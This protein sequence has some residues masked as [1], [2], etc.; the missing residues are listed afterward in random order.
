MYYFD[1]F[2]WHTETEIPGRATEVSPPSE[3]PLGLAANWT[4]YNWML[5]QY[6]PPPVVNPLEEQW[7]SVRA[8]RNQ[9]LKDTDWTQLADISDPMKTINAIYRA[10][11][12]S[13]PQVQ[14]DP[15]NI[16][17]PAKP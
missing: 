15:Y 5:L 16:V 14:T 2:G 9:L 7:K 6:E 13:I 3:I 17:W 12:R 8:Q 10:Q 4:G 1:N 11:L